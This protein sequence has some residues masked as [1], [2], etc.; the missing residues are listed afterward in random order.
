MSVE[1]KDNKP[2]MVVPMEGYTASLVKGQWIY[3]AD[4]AVPLKAVP[5]QAKYK[6]P[7]QFKI[8]EEYEGAAETFYKSNLANMAKEIVLFL[9]KV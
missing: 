5:V 4:E 3:K 1:E 6:D 8:M 2:S 9:L 7:V